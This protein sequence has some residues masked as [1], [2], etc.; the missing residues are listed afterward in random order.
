V[1]IDKWNEMQLAFD[2]ELDEVAED[3]EERAISPE[4]ARLISEA[5]RQA[6]ESQPALLEEDGGWKR[7][8]VRLREQ[9][10]PWRIACY[11]AWAASPRQGRWPETLSKLATDVL[12]LR[13]PRTIHTWRKK[14]PSLDAVVAMLQAAPLFEHRRDVINALIQM[15]T[16]P[17]YKAFNDRKLFL[18]MIGDYVP[19]S[20]LSLKNSGKANDLSE[21]SDAELDL[22]AGEIA[23]RR[24]LLE[25]D[26][27][28]DDDQPDQ[29]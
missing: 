18:E 29:A 25:D 26:D 12:G 3:A 10:W 4:E 11:I 23:E 14:H 7:E 20:Q 8:Y 1:A 24:N 9:G 2:L 13:G 22:L 21:L 28:R 15:A 27:D 6:F 17:D 16:T 5:A 19:K